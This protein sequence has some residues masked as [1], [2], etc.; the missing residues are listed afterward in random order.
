MAMS[1][2]R[3]S[4]KR[5]ESITRADWDVITRNTAA[6]TA[7]PLSRD[8]AEVLRWLD[9][10]HLKKIG[11]RYMPTACGIIPRKGNKTVSKKAP[12][13]PKA[14]KPKAPKKPKA[15]AKK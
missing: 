5:F 13:A 8:L 14:A 10:R 9:K 2:Q 1:E 7:P 11:G 15:K 12:K 6:G 3:L 4:G